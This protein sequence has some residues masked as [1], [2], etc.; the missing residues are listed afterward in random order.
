MR[1]SEPRS[2]RDVAEFRIRARL[3]LTERKLALCVESRRTVVLVPGSTPLCKLTRV[4]RDGGLS[5]RAELCRVGVCDAGVPTA[6]AGSLSRDWHG[7]VE[8][9]GMPRATIDLGR[10]SIAFVHKASSN[11]E[12]GVPVTLWRRG[13][14]LE[15]PV[16]AS[17]GP[18][19]FCTGRS[20]LADTL[21]P[22]LFTSRARC[23]GVELAVSDSADFQ[24]EK[25]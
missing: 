1:D 5:E 10:A 7:L 21:R 4:A 17:K 25:L 16:A 3:G 23:M 15:R 9:D 19:L 13:K 6:Q 22:L 8:R 18:L 24:Y 12:T 11:A 20:W 14:A 2:R